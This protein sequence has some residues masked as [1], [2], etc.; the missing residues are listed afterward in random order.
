MIDERGGIVLLIPHYANF[1]WITAYGNDFMQSGRR[2]R[3]GIQ[4]LAKDVYLDGLFKIHPCPLSEAIMF[5]NTPPPA[6]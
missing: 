6:K 1:E 5:R 3:A 2:A 4:A